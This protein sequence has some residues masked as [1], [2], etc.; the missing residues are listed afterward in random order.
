[1]VEQRSAGIVTPMP[2][3]ALKRRRRSARTLL[4]AGIALL[5][6]C[7]SAFA[8]SAKYTG[9]VTGGGAV[10]FRLGGD[11]VKRF[12]ASV[13]VTCVSV[14]PARSDTEI[15]VVA[16]S[17]SAELSRT[18]RFALKLDL[19]KQ[20]FTDST[21]EV[22]ETLYAV[23]ASVEGRVPGHSSSGTVKVSYNKYWTAYDP[24]TGFFVLTPVSCFSGKTKVPWHASSG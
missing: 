9:S 19:P 14:A 22:I 1:M 8:A 23:K 11:T 24:S 6:L 17:A 10:S 18:D 7:A 5:A 4:I 16:P 20:Q 21:G 2:S 3:F 15:Y 13:T 12:Q